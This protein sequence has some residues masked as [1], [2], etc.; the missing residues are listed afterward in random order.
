MKTYPI[1]VARNG[2]RGSDKRKRAKVQT[3][4]SQAYK[5]ET[6]VNEL[7]LKQVDPIHVYTWEVIASGCGLPFDVVQKLGFSI[8]CGS[9]GFTAWRHDLTY[10]QAMASHGLPAH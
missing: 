8:D 7:L 5:L 10:E 2:Y 9:G 1:N 4:N 6:Y 3:E